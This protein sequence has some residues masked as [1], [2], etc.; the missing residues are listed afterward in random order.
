MNIVIEKCCFI[1][2]FIRKNKTKPQ[3][4]VKLLYSQCCKLHIGI[5][6]SKGWCT[7]QRKWWC[8]HFMVL[9]LAI[10][11]SLHNIL[12]SLILV[13]LKPYFKCLSQW[14]FIS[15]SCLCK[16]CFPMFLCQVAFVCT[17]LWFTWI[18]ILARL[19]SWFFTV[20][21]FGHNSYTLGSTF[22]SF[23]FSF[24]SCFQNNVEIHVAH[25]QSGLSQMGNLHA[26]AANNTNRDWKLPFK[27]TASSSGKSSSFL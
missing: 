2:I 18:F 20:E 7:Q 5:D 1:S 25:I 26:F 8:F 6:S 9:I 10:R 24:H 21:L 12:I 17:A 14:L 15:G 19:T 11:A 3:T 22:L 27:C 4:L 16:L 23:F 13:M